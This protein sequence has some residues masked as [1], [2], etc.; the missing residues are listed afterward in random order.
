MLGSSLQCRM[1][2]LSDLNRAA[3]RRTRYRTASQTTRWAANGKHHRGN[4][5][6]GRHVEFLNGRLGPISMQLLADDVIEVGLL[7]LL[8]A[9]R[10]LIIEHHFT[11][12][13]S[14]M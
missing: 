2:G 7:P 13:K 10:K 5:Y 3:H 8:E 12:R 11:R 1:W 4:F 14:L 9:K 6:S